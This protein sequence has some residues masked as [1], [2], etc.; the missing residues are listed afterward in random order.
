VKAKLE[1]MG[2]EVVGS[3]PEQFDAFVR[4]ELAKWAKV[5]RTNKISVD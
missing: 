5:V 2:L 4:A 3:T 1:A